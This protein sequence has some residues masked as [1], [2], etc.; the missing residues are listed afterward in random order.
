MN[1]RSEQRREAIRAACAAR[2]ITLTERAGYCILR[3]R[4]V[5][6]KVADL[7]QIDLRDLEPHNY[8]RQE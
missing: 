3:G 2:G 7:A 8:A 5:D 1:D 6:M 4:G